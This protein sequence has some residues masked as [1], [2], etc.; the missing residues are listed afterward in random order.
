MYVVVTM[1]VD[2]L[3]AVRELVRVSR[4]GGRVLTTEFLWRKP[5]TPEAR[6]TFQ[7]EVCQGITFDTKEDWLQIY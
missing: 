5:P 1:F 7:S 4:P 2:R 6:Q 3:Q